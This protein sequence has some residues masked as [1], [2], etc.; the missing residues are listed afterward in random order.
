MGELARASLC[1][2]LS[3]AARMAISEDTGMPVYCCRKVR[4]SPVALSSAAREVYR[5]IS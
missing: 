4:I 2:V 1:R 5:A 3:E